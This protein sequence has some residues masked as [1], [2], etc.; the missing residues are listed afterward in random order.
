MFFVGRRRVRISFTYTLYSHLKIDLRCVITR[1][2]GTSTIS[3]CAEFR[4]FS[5][6]FC[7]LPYKYIRC[8]NPWGSECGIRF[9][10]AS[11]SSSAVRRLRYWCRQSKDKRRGMLVKDVSTTRGRTLWLGYVRSFHLQSRF[12]TDP[13]F[14]KDEIVTTL[15]KQRGPYERCKPTAQDT[16]GVVLSREG[17]EKLLPRYK[18]CIE[19]NGVYVEK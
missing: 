8:I 10:Q 19:L 11:N 6:S 4:P 14:L 16:G 3:P 13:S 18:N 12:G 2:T 17:T 15:C 7:N 1:Y 5:F 9:L